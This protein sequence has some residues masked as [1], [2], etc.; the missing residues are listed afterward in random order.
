MAT[1]S[2]FLRTPPCSSALK[3]RV[4]PPPD[5]MLGFFPLRLLQRRS[6]ETVWEQGAIVR[7]APFGDAVMANAT[8]IEAQK[9]TGKGTRAVNRLRLEGLVPANL[10]GHGQP[11]AMMTVANDVVRT[12][13][14]SGHKLVEIHCDGKVETALVREVQW[15]SFS[16]F[17]THVDFVRI[18]ANERVH[19]VVP[20]QLRG[21]APGVILGGILEQPVHTLHIEASAVDVPDMIVVKIDALQLG[22]SIHVRDLTDLPSGVTVKGAADQII[23]H[24]V[25]PRAEE[26]KPIEPGAAQ[27]SPEVV[28]KKKDSEDAAK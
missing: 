26:I 14:Y 15:D 2:V 18:D 16:K 4:A 3:L 5:K 21:T 23:V 12:L 24:V 8:K 20:I 7:I 11:S 13:V 9:R 22:Q 10:Y 17:I 27:M 25:S 6:V 1:G 28:K 19:V